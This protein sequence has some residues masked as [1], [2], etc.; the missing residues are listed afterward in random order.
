MDW[1]LH[2]AERYR[3]HIQSGPFFT[4]LAHAERPID[5]IWVH[6]L[7]HQSREFTQALCLRY[8]LCRDKR[9]QTRSP[10]THSRRP[11]IPSSSR[12][13]WT[14]T[15]SWRAVKRAASR[16][17]RRRSTRRRSAGAPPSTSRTACRQL[18]PLWTDDLQGRLLMPAHAASPARFRT[19][20]RR[21]TRRRPCCGSASRRA[22]SHGTAR[23]TCRRRETRRSAAGTE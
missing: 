17:A 2:H 5:L 11:I 12:H 23:S 9:F 10:S 6:Q 21:C 14:S 7:V 15:G 1:L 8:S 3:C 19:R 20:T 22:H 4:R 13:G 18:A 16:R